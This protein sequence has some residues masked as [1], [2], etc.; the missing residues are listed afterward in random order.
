[1]SLDV[2]FE[3]CGL[4]NISASVSGFFFDSMMTRQWFGHAKS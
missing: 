4:A 2:F 3:I 1:M